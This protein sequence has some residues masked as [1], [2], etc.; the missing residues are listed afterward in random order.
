MKTLYRGLG[1]F[2]ASYTPWK[3]QDL[4]RIAAIFF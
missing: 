3:K 4:C 1:T 2:Y